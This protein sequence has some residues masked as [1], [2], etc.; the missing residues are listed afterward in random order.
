MEIRRGRESR[1]VE[2]TNQQVKDGQNNLSSKQMLN[3]YS[4]KPELLKDSHSNLENSR[5]SYQ[6][7]SLES[8]LNAELKWMS[9]KMSDKAD[10]N[11]SYLNKFNQYTQSQSKV[12]KTLEM[13][14]KYSKASLSSL[15]MSGLFFPG[16]NKSF[17][18]DLN[19]TST[20]IIKTTVSGCKLEVRSTYNTNKNYLSTQNSY[21]FKAK[22]RPES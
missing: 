19:K 16:S 21:S 22:I 6:I 13:N 15:K 11:K 14:R 4:S 17:Q 5:P 9:N 20:K 8:T 10:T 12:I 1:N 7:N 18:S 2:R 3:S